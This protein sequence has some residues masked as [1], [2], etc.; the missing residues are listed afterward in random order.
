MVGGGDLVGQFADAG[1]LDEVI[2]QHRARHARA[3]GVRSCP[4]PRPRAAR[5]GAEQGVRVR[6]LCAF[7]VPAP[8]QWRSELPLPQGPRHGERLRA[9][10]RPRRHGPRRP[11]RR[12]GPRAVRPPRRHRR[13]RRAARG[14][15]R[16]RAGSWTT[17]TPTARSARCAATASASSPATSS[18]TRARRRR[19]RSTPATASRP[20][21]S[22]VTS[23]TVDMGSPEVFA[24]A[25]R[26]AST[27]SS[28]E[29]LHVSMGNPHAVAFVDS[30]DEAGS[31]LEEPGY[32]RAVYPDGVNV[33][34]VVRRSAHHV[35]MRVHERGSG[36]TRSCG[37]GAC[38]VMVAAALADEAPRGTAYRDRRPRRQPRDHLDRGRPDPDDRSGAPRRRGHDRPVRVEC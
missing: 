29:A 2:A 8:A 13:R 4:A 33:E 7:E 25:R 27:V 26:S 20:S 24:D 1:L 38:A 3:P 15:R 9:P 22:P 12:P 36:E 32:D 16:R 28:H 23:I 17:A 5:G 11:R 31:L 35:A 14:P 30:L 34:F 18:T 37:T 6:P 10:A 21:P 19:S